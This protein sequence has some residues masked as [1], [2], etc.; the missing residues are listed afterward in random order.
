MDLHRISVKFFLADPAVADAEAMIGV[1]HDWIQQAKVPG[2]LIDV[3]DYGHMVDGPGVILI[4]DDVDYALDMAQGRPGL[5]HVRKRGGG[6]LAEQLPAAFGNAIAAC[7]VLASEQGMAFATN[8]VKVT[9]LDRLNAP[10]TQATLDA[11]GGEIESFAASLLGD[12]TLQRDSEDERC[13]FAV[14][15]KA[16]DAPDLD[17]LQQRLTAATA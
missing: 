16:G 6:S 2:M 11:V 3:A 7:K 5:L 9:L 10:N 17:T 12:V 14:N 1:F 8:D 13:A 15:V 4:G